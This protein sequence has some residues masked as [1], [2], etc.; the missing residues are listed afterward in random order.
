[1]AWSH[2]AE[3]DGHG[4][5]TCVGWAGYCV[6][7]SDVNSHPRSGVVLLGKGLHYHVHSDGRGLGSHRVDHIQFFLHHL[8]SQSFRRLSG[9]YFYWNSFGRT[10]PLAL[11]ISFSSHFCPDS[12]SYFS[13]STKGSLPVSLL[14][15]RCYW[16]SIYFL[17]IYQHIIACKDITLLFATTLALSYLSWQTRN[18]VC[19]NPY[20]N[21]NS[22]EGRKFKWDFSLWNA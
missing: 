21:F 12:N 22:S 16:F 11:P 1:M 6:Q 10:V 15:R 3:L 13:E 2:R 17:F 7:S 8:G 18:P 14:R 9:I 20:W 19:W 5:C 4:L